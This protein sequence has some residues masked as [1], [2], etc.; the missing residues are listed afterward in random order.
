MTHPL[1]DMK[2][3]YHKSKGLNQ[4]TKAIRIDLHKLI[5]RLGK[6]KISFVN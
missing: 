6:Q 5:V 3:A 4:Q 1:T 2:M